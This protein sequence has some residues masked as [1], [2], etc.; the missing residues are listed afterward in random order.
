MYRRHPY[1]SAV[2]LGA[3]LGVGYMLLVTFIILP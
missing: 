1:L 2:S 3:L